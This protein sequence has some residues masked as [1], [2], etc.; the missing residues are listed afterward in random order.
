MIVIED[1][2]RGVGRGGHAR[3]MNRPSPADNRQFLPGAG[4]YFLAD[5]GTLPAN[6]SRNDIK[7]I[8]HRHPSEGA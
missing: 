8:E 7:I 3:N 4:Y 1:E 5:L 2:M 6:P